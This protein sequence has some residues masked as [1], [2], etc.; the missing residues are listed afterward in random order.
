MH[1]ALYGHI[2]ADSDSYAQVS[3][4][5]LSLINVLFV[6]LLVCLFLFLINDLDVGPK[7]IVCN[8]AGD[9]KL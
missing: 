6:C 5:E 2:E 3:I 7:C 8:F 4:W 1:V 9:I